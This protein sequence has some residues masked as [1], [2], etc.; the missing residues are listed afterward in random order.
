MKEILQNHEQLLAVF[1][2]IKA[3][4]FPEL[5][6]RLFEAHEK[7]KELFE[8]AIQKDLSSIGK[9]VKVS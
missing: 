8:C 6:Y 9:D 4:E 5:L 3:E 2:R 1:E 7:T